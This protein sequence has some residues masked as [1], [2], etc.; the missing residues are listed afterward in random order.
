[1]C[2]SAGRPTEPRVQCPRSRSR[3]LAI[4]SPVFLS[5][6]DKA[7]D[8]AL[9]SELS[10]AAAAQQT[11]AVDAGTY[12][13]STADLLSTGYR[14]G[15]LAGVEIVAADATSFC[16]KAGSRSFDNVM[17]YTSL[18]HTFNSVPCG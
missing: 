5:P 18:E 11:W 13:T 16:L 1:M 6:R 3:G 15:S 9:K 12:T 8:S 7:N 17:Y 2:R 4:A 14:P 10:Y